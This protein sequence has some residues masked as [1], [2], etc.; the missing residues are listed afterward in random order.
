MAKASKP[1]AVPGRTQGDL[2][3]ETRDRILE[4]TLEAIGRHGLRKLGMI[5]VATV[6]GVSRGTLYRYFPSRETL[7]EELFDYERQRFEVGVNEALASV[8][9]GQ[10]R[11]DAHIDFILGYLRTHP[12]LAGLIETEPRYVLGFLEAHFESFRRATGAMLEPI[13]SAAG[14]ADQ[15]D[16]TFESL[17]DLLFRVLLSFF[18][19]PPDPRKEATSLRAVSA[20]VAALASQPT[21]RQ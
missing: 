12:A 4:G 16:V 19:F 21:G 18:L 15:D 6:S 10:A 20:V 11:L 2:Q 9:P 13:L 3:A 14:V 7:L 1:I 8:P 5:D 17:S